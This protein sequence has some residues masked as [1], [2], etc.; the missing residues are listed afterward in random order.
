MVDESEPL[1]AACCSNGTV[2]GLFGY[3]SATGSVA[4]ATD[5][6][7]FCLSTRF[8]SKEQRVGW[9]RGCMISADGND[10]AFAV[11]VTIVKR[12]DKVMSSSRLRSISCAHCAAVAVLPIPRESELIRT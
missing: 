3:R 10:C 8:T 6:S 1:V 9:E 11:S 7:P 4:P 12:V 5:E 2:G